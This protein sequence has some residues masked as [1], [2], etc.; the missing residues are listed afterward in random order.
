[1]YYHRWKTPAPGYDIAEHILPFSDWLCEHVGPQVWT[2]RRY[3]HKQLLDQE[4]DYW[5][6]K[7]T[8]TPAVDPQTAKRNAA[9]TVLLHEGEN[10]CLVGVLWFLNTPIDFHKA[11]FVLQTAQ[12]VDLMHF[13]LACL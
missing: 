13:R 7:I 8:E 2:G 4:L 10:W 12:A 6:D 3:V 11:T 5:C 1:M 9:Q